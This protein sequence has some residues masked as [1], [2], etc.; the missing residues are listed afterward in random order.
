MSHS[1]PDSSTALRSGR[2]DKVDYSPPSAIP[3]L[4]LE[5]AT[6]LIGGDPRALCLIGHEVL[7]EPVAGS[8]PHLG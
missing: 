7:S 5:A 3:K 6:H 4:A 1:Q 2:N 8:A